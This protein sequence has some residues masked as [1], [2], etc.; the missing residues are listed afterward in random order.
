MSSISAGVLG[1]GAGLGGTIAIGVTVD[2]QGSAILPG[3][4]SVGVEIPFDALIRSN[5]LLADRIGSIVF[6]VWKGP[7]AAYPLSGA[8]SIVG[9]DPPTISGDIKSQDTTLSGWTV[10]ISAGEVV[11]F[12]ITSASAIQVCSLTMPLTKL[13]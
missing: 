3:V 1:G 6:D 11:Q 13:S 7:Y 8:N 10:M 4:T 2:G 12:H 9:V 5:V